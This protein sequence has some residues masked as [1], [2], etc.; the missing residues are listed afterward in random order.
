[1]ELIQKQNE[2]ITS[3]KHLEYL[4]RL[5]T[6]MENSING[7]FVVSKKLNAHYF[8]SKPKHKIDEDNFILEKINNSIKHFSKEI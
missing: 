4:Y 6:V 3:V 2:F 5:K 8:K 1:M 7:K